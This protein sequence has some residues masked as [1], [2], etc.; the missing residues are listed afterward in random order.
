MI[1]VT[2][3]KTLEGKVIVVE[4]KNDMQIRGTLA[5]V[6]QYL[7]FKLTGVEAVD[8]ERFPQLLAV[9]DLFVRGSVIRYVMVPPEEVDTALL[10]DAA[11]VEALGTAKLA[12]SKAPAAAAGGAGRR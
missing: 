2:F 4:L 1:F 7:N 9:K 12:A 6:D 10:Q 11:R 3:F 8:K 5:S